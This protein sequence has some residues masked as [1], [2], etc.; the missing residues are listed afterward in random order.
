MS[1]FVGGIL[2]PSC[3]TCRSFHAH[4]AQTRITHSISMHGHQRACNT[5]YSINGLAKQCVSSTSIL[6]AVNAHVQSLRQVALNPVITSLTSSLEKRLEASGGVDLLL[7][8]PPYVPTVTSEAE[9]A[10]G[11]CGIAG[12]WAGG[13]DGMDVTEKVL[14]SLKVALVPCTYVTRRFFADPLLSCAR[15]CFPRRGGSTSLQ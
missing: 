10:Q 2:G 3:C 15:T 6:P 4:D 13:Q 7:F 11:D 14:K 9:D 12:A 5:R 8:N 1:A